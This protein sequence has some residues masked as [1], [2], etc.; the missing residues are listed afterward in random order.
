MVRH[1]VLL[2]STRPLS[3]YRAERRYAILDG[4]Q[5]GFCP[6]RGPDASLTHGHPT[7][8]LFTLNGFLT[9]AE[10]TPRNPCAFAPKYVKCA[11]QQRFQIKGGH[12]GNRTA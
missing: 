12:H 3:A 7:T 5:V 2:S 8:I 6:F 1:N 4:T 10:S 11:L 9:V